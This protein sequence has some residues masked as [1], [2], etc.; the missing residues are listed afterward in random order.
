[1]MAV[2]V[3]SLLT[4]EQARE[5]NCLV[6]SCVT[7]LSYQLNLSSIWALL[8]LPRRRVYKMG[9]THTSGLLAAGFCPAWEEHSGFHG[10]HRPLP[11]ALMSQVYGDLRVRLLEQREAGFA[12]GCQDLAGCSCQ[13]SP[14]SPGLLSLNQIL[15][16][17]LEMIHRSC[18]LT[19]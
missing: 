8:F 9:C 14:C 13:A 5:Y 19:S 18:G 17:C 16:V 7:A 3:W 1:M 15:S 10:S 4:S 12:S 11:P 2:T 6:V